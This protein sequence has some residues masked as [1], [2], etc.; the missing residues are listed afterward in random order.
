MAHKFDSSI[1]FVN[2]NCYHTPS[3]F[4]YELIDET[5]AEVF[6]IWENGK[7]FRIERNG[8]KS[9]YMYV[10]LMRRKMY[11]EIADSSQKFAIARTSFLDNVTGRYGDILTAA[12]RVEAENDKKRYENDI[13]YKNMRNQIKNILRGALL[14]RFWKHLYGWR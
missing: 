5:G 4:K 10:H 2:I 8:D 3:I 9:E 7:L 11:G 12:K 1:K 13:R 14:F 6:Y